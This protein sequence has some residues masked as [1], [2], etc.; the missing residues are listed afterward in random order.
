M[1]RLTYI[2][3]ARIPTDQAHSIQI[4][5][6]CEAFADLGLKVELVVPKRYQPDPKLRGVDPYKYYSVK[7][8]FKIKRMF[9][10]DFL[11]LAPRVQFLSSLFF[12]LQDMSFSFVAIPTILRAEL[13]YTR[14]KLVAALCIWLSRKVAYEAHDRAEDKWVDR[15]IAS[16]SMVVGITRSIVRSWQQLGAQIQYAPDGVSQ[17]F[18]VDIPKIEA[19]KQ[20]DL[21]NDKPI[22]LYTGNLYQWKGVDTLAEAA[23]KLSQYE[24]YFVG[25]S[26]EEPVTQFVQ[27][28]KSTNNVHVIGHQR[29]SN[30]PI[31]LH[32]ADI[33]VV[34]NSAKTK[35]GREDTSPLKLFEYLASGT[36]I[37]AS[38]VPA[39]REIVSDKEVTFFEADSIKDLTK[40]IQ[41]VFTTYTSTKTLSGRK[42]AKSYIWRKRAE[43][44]L[45]QLD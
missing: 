7:A 27:K 10:I 33:L 18:F 32:A 36:P 9:C 4:M 11:W 28:Y 44:I 16:N 3:N 20:L 8:N 39:I 5:K 26:Q 35:K 29:Y 17:E 37:V 23:R 15:L 30:I 1:K 31:W 25:G 14:S 45:K 13:V 24:F 19:R 22:V 2:A 42:L 21:P 40:A 6:M 38:D 41:M 34:P 43:D 12:I